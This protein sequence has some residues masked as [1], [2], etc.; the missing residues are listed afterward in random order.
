V[1]VSG[2][3]VRLLTTSYLRVH[4]R[5]AVN[6]LIVVPASTWSYRTTPSWRLPAKIS[7]KLADD[8]LVV[9]SVQHRVR[10]LNEYGCNTFDLV[11]SMVMIPRNNHDRNQRFHRT[12]LRVTSWVEAHANAITMYT[13]NQKVNMMSCETYESLG[14]IPVLTVT[15]GRTAMG[16]TMVGTRACTYAILFQWESLRQGGTS[17]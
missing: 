3:A 2:F 4:V 9:L 5:L 17:W 6:W 12:L 14:H 15:L 16:K 1:Y 8:L 7:G 13:M 11:A 10:R